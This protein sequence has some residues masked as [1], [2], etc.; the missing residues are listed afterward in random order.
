ME[1]MHNVTATVQLRANKS[2][3]PKQLAEKI[4]RALER[5][6]FFVDGTFSVSVRPWNEE[7][8]RKAGW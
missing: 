2:Y 7:T 4:M 1:A 3:L 5:D 8:G 6:E